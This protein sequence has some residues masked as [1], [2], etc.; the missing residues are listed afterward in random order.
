MIEQFISRNFNVKTQRVIMQANAII[1]E[2]LAKGFTLTLRQLYYQF[3]ARGLI[4]NTQRSYNRLGNIIS[5][6]RMAGLTDWNAIEDR[7]RNLAC[8]LYTSP[9]PRDS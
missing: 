9:S 2:Y 7:T 6:A 1:N 8:L 4:P 3:V 5:N